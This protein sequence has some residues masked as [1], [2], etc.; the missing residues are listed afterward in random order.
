[1]NFGDG[2]AA[3]TYSGTPTSVTHTYTSSGTF[4]V[5]VTA[6]DSFGNT[7]EGGTSVLISAQGAADGVDHDDDDQSDRRASTSRSR[8]R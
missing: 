7:S 3:V 5:R 8:R 1:M 4:A 6:F 2:T